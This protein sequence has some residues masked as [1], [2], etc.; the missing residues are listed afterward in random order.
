[1]IGG[2]MALREQA[3]NAL[4]WYA[5]LAWGTWIGGTLYQMLVIVPMWS[6]SPP[7]SV[8]AFFLGTEYNHTIFNFF[9]PPF[10]AARVIPIILA[11]LLAW[12]LPK[13]RIA[14][15]VAALCLVA[16]VAF[17]LT[18]IYPINAVL[19]EHAGQGRPAAEITAL[20]H[21]WIWADRLRF[22]VGVVAFVAILNAFRWP[23]HSDE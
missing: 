7:E 15:G 14:L 9:G 22:G 19:F 12:H 13:H 23:L 11:L 20:V 2:S 6:S 21:A 4:L 1:M 18:Y 5:V 3:L 17:T 8:R 16:A 10:M